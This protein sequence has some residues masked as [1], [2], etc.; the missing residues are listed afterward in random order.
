MTIDDLK[1]EQDYNRE[2]A[3][4]PPS[5][6]SLKGIGKY[7]FLKS[8]DISYTKINNLSLL[9]NLKLLEHLDISH[10]KIT[11]ISVILELP[12]LKDITKEN[13]SLPIEIRDASLEEIKTYYKNKNR[14]KYLKKIFE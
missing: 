14:K 6:S 3:Y 5:V 12:N 4:I 2:S 11:D 9:K 8:L 7:R 10:T 13:N 1:D